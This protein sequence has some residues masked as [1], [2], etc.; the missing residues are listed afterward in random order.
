MENERNNI[1]SQLKLN[2]LL[3]KHIKRVTKEKKNGIIKIDFNVRFVDGKSGFLIGDEWFFI[4]GILD[5]VKAIY[6]SFIETRLNGLVY[7]SDGNIIVLIY[8]NPTR[9]FIK[10]SRLI[11]RYS[12][13]NINWDDV[14][15]ELVRGKAETKSFLCYNDDV[16]V[17]TCDFI[18]NNRK[19]RDKIVVS[20]NEDVS[21]DY[22][23]YLKTMSLTIKTPFN[24]EKASHYITA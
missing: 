23:K 18:K 2:V 16:C 21:E 5:P 20:F 3:A 10:L 15:T 17:S 14:Y 12:G 11:Y 1:I 13:T 22:N 9:S 24:K 19:N 4:N 7:K 8:G 6:N